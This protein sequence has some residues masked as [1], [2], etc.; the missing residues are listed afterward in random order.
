MCDHKWYTCLKLDFIKMATISGSHGSDKITGTSKNDVL[1]GNG[2]NDEIKGSKGND[3]IQG[4]TGND[5]LYG[6]DGEDILVGDELWR[7]VSDN[8]FTIN[9]LAEVFQEISS[10]YKI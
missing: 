9:D 4:G 2:G 7:K 5:K 8:K 6:G 10:I 1:K 3:T